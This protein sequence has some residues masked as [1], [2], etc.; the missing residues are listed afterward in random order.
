MKEANPMQINRLTGIVEVFSGAI[1]KG[2][3][4]H[5]I[6]FRCE[7]GHRWMIM[8]GPTN[9][10]IHPGDVVELIDDELLWIPANYDHDGQRFDVLGD[11]HP[12]LKGGTA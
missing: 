8:I 12:V 11:L 5:A 6:I 7:D 4:G 1:D 3:H 10:R 2:R 9:Y